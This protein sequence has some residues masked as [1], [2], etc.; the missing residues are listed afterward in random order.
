M[1]PAIVDGTLSIEQSL[2]NLS[3]VLLVLGILALLI[4]SFNKLLRIAR[5]KL[6]TVA[7]RHVRALE[8]RGIRFISQSQLILIIRSVST[9]LRFAITLILIIA[10]LPILF[11]FFPWTKPIAQ[12]LI[13]AALTPI[14]SAAVAF[15]DYIPNL[16]TIIIIFLLTR[17]LVRGIRFVARGIGDGKIIITGFFPDWAM[18]TYN[19]VRSL[20][21]IF[22]FVIIFPYLPG[23]NSKV[24]QGVSVFLGVL[25]SFGSSSAISN[26][27]AGIVLTYMRPFQIGDRVRILDFLGDVTQK[28]LLVTRLKTVKNE[29]ITIP[30]SSILNAHVLNYSKYARTGDLILHTTVTIGYDA[31]WKQVQDLL[32]KAGKAAYGVVQSKEPFVLQTALNDFYVSYQLNVYV[33]STDLPLV[34]SSLHQNIQDEFNAAGVEIMSPHYSSLRDG[35]HI[36]IPNENVS[37]NYQAPGFKI[38]S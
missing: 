8:L 37:P 33:E 32:F 38:N 10:S 17:Y 16:F 4:W 28:N 25:F 31:P 6:V 1:E 12:G 22:M 14:H 19:I 30:N 26:V 5:A 35:N 36:A 34:Y 18:P 27:V 11:G 24:F 9:F 3:L 7:E 13:E 20:L 23:S 15:V 21:Y 29:D 2:Q